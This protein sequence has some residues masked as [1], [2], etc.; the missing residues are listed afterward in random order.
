MCSRGK[1]QR[2][3]GE[4][5]SSPCCRFSFILCSTFVRSTRPLSIQGCC[6]SRNWERHIFSTL[7][8]GS[9]LETE[10]KAAS[11]SGRG[12]GK[13]SREHIS[14]PAAAVTERREAATPPLS[15]RGVAA[16]GRAT[17]AD[18]GTAVEA[19]GAG[20]WITVSLAR[21]AFSI[22]LTIHPSSRSC[23]MPPAPPS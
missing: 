17:L 12:D 21:S 3:S 19:F 1:P 2:N 15:L 10:L 23:C 18:K 13:G 4:S 22:C 11:L 20:S 9:C 16:D 7:S 6:R 14:W 5:S 8:S